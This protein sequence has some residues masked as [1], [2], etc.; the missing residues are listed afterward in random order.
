MRCVLCQLWKRFQWETVR[1]TGVWLYQVQRGTGRRR[2]VRGAARGHQPID[3]HWQQTG[4]W[5]KAGNPPS[6]ASGVSKP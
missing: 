6:G 1:D 2:I 3:L 5:S 4:E